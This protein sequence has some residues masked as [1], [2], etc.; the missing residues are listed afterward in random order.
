MPIGISEKN[1]TL[2]KLGYKIVDEIK[3]T[4]VYFTYNLEVYIQKNY[5]AILIN[6]DKTLNMW[7]Q[8][9]L[10]ILGKVQVIKTSGISQLMFIFNSSDP[11]TDVVQKANNMLFRF[12]WNGTDKMKRLA[13]IADIENGG[14]KMPHLES[15]ID[16]LKIVWVKRFS[17]KKF[18]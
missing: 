15:I 18:H 2:T 13:A 9:N 14:I 17:M 1:D 12:L 7:K 5:K 4:G 11:P 10:S 3:I 8:R 16:A 6:I